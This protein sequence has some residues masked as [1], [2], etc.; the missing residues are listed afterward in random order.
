MGYTRLK[1]IESNGTQYIDTGFV[2]NQ[3]T[4]MVLDVMFTD[5]T[6]SNNFAG[7]RYTTSSKAFTIGLYEENWR[8]GYGSSLPNTYIPSGNKRHIADLN[9]NVF[10]VDGNVI[11]SFAEETFSGYASIYLGAIHARSE[12]WGFGRIYG[13]QIYDNDVL[14]RDYIPMA[15]EQGVCGLW[16]KVNDTF[17]P[18]ANGNNFFGIREDN[19]LPIGYTLCE[20]IESAGTQYIDTG[21]KPNNNTRVTCDFEFMTTP[22]SFNYCIFGS[23][24]SSS[25]TMYEFLWHSGNAYFRSDYNKKATNTWSTNAVG[26][27]VVDK[28]KETTTFSGESKSYTNESFSSS[29]N[30]YLFALNQ[31]DAA[32]WYA[33]ARIYSCQIYD[34]GMLVRDYVPCQDMYGVYGLYD[35]TNNV[36]YQSATSYGFTGKWAEDKKLLVSPAEF[37]KRLMMLAV[38]DTKPDYTILG[39]HGVAIMDIKG[40]FYPDAESWQNAGSPTANGIAVSDGT[41]RFCIAK[42]M[43]QHVCSAS[44]FTDAEYWGAYGTS[45]SGVTTTTSSSTAKTDFNGVAN[46]EAIVA[47]VQSSDGYFNK[48][49]W[50]AASLCNDYIFPNGQHGYLGAVGEW[51]LVQGSIDT[52]NTLLDA[53]GEGIDTNFSACPYYWSSTQFN[54]YSAW[55]WFF[56]DKRCYNY[57]KVD[58]IRVRAFCTLDNPQIKVITF[59]IEGV[60]LTAEK[61]MTW[62]EYISS[63]FNHYP[64]KFEDY[65]GIVFVYDYVI[66]Y[67]NNIMLNDMSRYISVDEFIIE[68]HIYT[69]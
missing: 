69:Y 16:D 7:S 44:E 55:G 20:Y 4:R 14:V 48:S 66:D 27:F 18:S 17:Y 42:D 3:D 50:S 62:R 12:Y 23:R 61:G 9:K 31:T 25:S 22:A 26:R 65:N 45:V 8:I 2:P 13:C 60:A 47:Q 43:I 33:T 19:G 59:Y 53:I 37:R 5:L 36:F 41:H 52:I 32:Q 38:N 11:Y 46:T 58:S 67:K 40:K 30:L 64:Y 10:S 56:S 54:S 49:P 6:V 35:L 51:S 68:G 34:N 57:V 1:Y 24:A 63:G 29:Y 28:D 39:A 15:N 21:F